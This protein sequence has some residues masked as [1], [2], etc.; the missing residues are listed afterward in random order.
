MDISEG[1][2]AWRLVRLYNS[3]IDF[4]VI[5][6]ERLPRSLAYAVCYI[7]SETNQPDLLLKVGSSDESKVYL[8]G[9]QIYRQSEPR[10]YV[11]DQDVV[12]GVTLEQ[13]LNVLVF[14]LATEV[15][16]TTD[17]NWQGSIRFTD[18][19]G[20]EVKGIRATITPASDTDPGAI[21]NWLLLAP[22]P[23]DGTNGSTALAQ[24]QIPDEAHMRPRAG[25]RSR[26]G[27]SNLVWQGF[28]LHDYG[29]DFLELTGRTNA[30]WCVA[31]GVCYVESQES[32]T[33]LIMNVGSD[34]Q[35]KVYL[36]GKEIYRYDGPGRALVPDQDQARGVVLKPGINPLVFKVVNEKGEWR[37]SIR[38][39]DAGGQ[40]VK[41]IRVTLAPP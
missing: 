25:D 30:D 6:A 3:V 34:D 23:F 1:E 5:N 26:V 31:Y 33:N 16:E 14:K 4:N 19:A 10:T 37:G 41:G 40:P 29:L 15:E 27:G 21:H 9:K 38:F 12:T 13:G 7:H 17:F 36:N 20:Q 11:P 32:Q 2:R 22:I 24:E 8:N 28:H 39:T 35:A 18:A